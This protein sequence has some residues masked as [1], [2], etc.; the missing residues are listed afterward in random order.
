MRSTAAGSLNGTFAAGTRSLRRMLALVWFTR[1]K[2]P[3]TAAAIASTLR[4]GQ[5]I[6]A[7]QSL[8]GWQLATNALPITMH[9]TNLG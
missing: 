4:P 3:C 5:H 9:S 7:E 8:P 1:K 2:G 6:S